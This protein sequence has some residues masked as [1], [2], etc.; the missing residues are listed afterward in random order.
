MIQFLIIIQNPNQNV[1]FS[2]NKILKEVIKY[3]ILIILIQFT[4]LSNLC[5]QD[6]SQTDNHFTI[7][8]G[9]GNSMYDKIQSKVKL[10]T[11]KLDFSDVGQTNSFTF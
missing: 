10:I 11:I 7:E 5:S 6:Y 3:L 1:F 2:I 9:V 4:I 8:I